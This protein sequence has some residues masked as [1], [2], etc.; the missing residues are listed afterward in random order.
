MIFTL[1]F[2]DNLRP[3]LRVRHATK[4]SAQNIKRSGSDGG[5]PEIGDHAWNHIHLGPELGHVE[6]V[7]DIDG[8]EQ[9]LD[10]LADWKVQVAAFDHNVVLPM[11]IVGIQAQRVVG[12]DVADIGC[13]QPAILPR[14]AEAPAPLLTHDLDFGSVRRNR[15]E[16][17]PD[18]Q[19]GCQHGSD[20]DRS[21]YGEP[22]FELFVFG[23]VGCLPSLLVM[24][25][26]DA[27]GHERND[28][29][30]NRPGDPERDVDRVVDVAP[31][32]GDRRPPPRA[33][34]VK[35]H[36]A[37]C[38][39]KQ[40]D[41]YSHPSFI[42]AVKGYGYGIKGRS[43]RLSRWLTSHSPSLCLLPRPFNRS[44]RQN[45]TQSTRDAANL[46]GARGVLEF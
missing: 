42:L 8:A 11:R 34:E 44:R 37:D 46:V 19:A 5:Y 4:L 36:R 39:Q 23:I 31:V 38:D 22:P 15:D 13:A 3:H 16:L 7:Q 9:N 33:E 26:E 41:C 25:A 28:R 2:D 1:F 6:I 35:Q 12:T 30:E 14:E 43:S 21:P 27:I 24:K 17:V 20:A 40:Y 32:C 29:E 45:M 10:R 18:N